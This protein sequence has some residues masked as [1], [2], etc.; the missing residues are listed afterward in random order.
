MTGAAQ[1]KDGGDVTAKRYTFLA[2]AAFIALSPHAFAITVPIFCGS[3][4]NAIGEVTVNANGTGISGGF[5]SLVPNPGTPSL[6]GAAAACGEDHFNWYQIVTADNQTPAGLT[7]PYVDPPS[8]G[9]PIAFD[10]TWADTLPWYYDEWNPSPVPPGRTFVPGLTIQSKTHPNL[11]DFGDFPGGAAGLNLSFKTWLVSL[12]ANGSLHTFHS[13]FSWD[14][15]QPG[16]RVT[17]SVSNIQSLGDEWFTSPNPPT[18]A[19][20]NNIIGGFTTAVP[21]PSTLLLLSGGTV[22]FLFRRRRP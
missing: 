12:N 2:A 13:G 9:Y 6:A 4:P 20:Y 15:T 8:G 17:G 1:V 10:N 11:L 7:V 19:E 22:L 3:N 21:E 18:A 5:T 14:Y 16:A